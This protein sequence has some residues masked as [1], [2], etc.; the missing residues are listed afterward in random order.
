MPRKIFLLLVLV[1]VGCAPTI[2]RVPLDKTLGL[3][4]FSNIGTM[5]RKNISIGL[6]IGPKLKNLALASKVTVG[7][8]NESEAV[9]YKFYVGRN[10]TVRLIKAL[11][12]N[13]NKLKLLEQPHPSAGDN[14]DATMI[15]EFQDAEIFFK[16]MGSSW[17]C[18]SWLAVKATLKDNATGDIVWVGTTRAEDKGKY[19]RSALGINKT[20]ER[21][22][23]QLVRQISESENYAKYVRIWEGRKHD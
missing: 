13:V 5:E 1:V 14:L 12:Y 4:T 17:L 19:R 3:E 8:Y 23:A 10:F 15:V 9:I 22:V 2:V 20:I 11:A 18:E 7:A 21:A 6:Y 16:D